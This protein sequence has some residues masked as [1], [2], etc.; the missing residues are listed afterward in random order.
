MRIYTVAI[1]TFK[2]I[3]FI[4]NMSIY[5]LLIVL[6]QLLINTRNR[7]VKPQEM[8]LYLQNF[9]TLNNVEN[10]IEAHLALYLSNK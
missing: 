1:Y 10:D 5:K 8:K 9:S 4:S 3:N 6:S 2:S 7:I